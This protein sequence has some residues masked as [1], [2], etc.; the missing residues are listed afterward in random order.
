M[1][2]AAQNRLPRAAAIRQRTTVQPRKMYILGVAQADASPRTK[3][4]TCQ[5][6]ALEYYLGN[7]REASTN[8]YHRK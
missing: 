3:D 7:R 5:P 1:M 2:E 6:R 8:I 4:I